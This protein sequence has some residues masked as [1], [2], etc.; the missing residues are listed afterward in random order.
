MLKINLPTLLSLLGLLFVSQ[1]SAQF[2]Q[3]KSIAANEASINNQQMQ[4]SVIDA[5][6]DSPLKADINV[7][8]L[9]PR[10]GVTMKS[11]TDTTFEIRNYRLYTISCIE[12]GY[13]YYSD[14]FWPDE[15]AL[16][17]Q[18]VQ[19]RPLEVG[20]KTDVRDITFLG[21]KTEIYHKSKPALAEII[22][23][24]KLNPTVSIAVIGH[25]N[26]PDNSR[27]QRFYEKASV[28]RAEVVMNYLI[29][30]GGIDARRLSAKGAGNK[31]MIYIDPVTDWQN[32]ANRR[33]EIEVTGL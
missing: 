12:K 18:E 16:H 20:Q 14:K 24:L 23:F 33:I 29:E 27:S 5:N 11:V 10:K 15:K 7:Y 4:I 26:G 6:T 13:M 22:D 30:E 8:G 19:M 9:N 2:V 31:E 21:D 17:L 28:S 3:E 25:V 1:L 32:Q